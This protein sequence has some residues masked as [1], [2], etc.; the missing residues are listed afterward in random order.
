VGVR[1]LS[2]RIEIRMNQPKRIYNKK[3]VVVEV[4]TSL[5][6]FLCVEVGVYMRVLVPA[7]KG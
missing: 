3:V 7:G 2:V 4:S 1:R 6:L 5:S